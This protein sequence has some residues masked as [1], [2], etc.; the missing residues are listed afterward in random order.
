MAGKIKHSFTGLLTIY[1]LCL[2]HW[3]CAQSR[4]AQFEF[5]HIQQKDGL[6][7][8]Q[9]SCFLQDRDGFLWVGT[10]DGL[11]RYDGS[12]FVRFKNRRS[13]TNSLLHNTI[14]ALCED[15]AGNIWMAVERGIG[16]YEKKTGRFRS[17]TS[18]NGRELGL[19]TNILSDRNGDI[20]FTSYYAGLYCYRIKTGIFEWFSFSAQDTPQTV[21]TRIAV[22]GLV[23]DPQRNGLWLADKKEGLR[24]FDM[25]LRTFTDYPNDNQLRNYQGHFI[26]SL[27]RDGNRLVFADATEKHIV[28]YD[29]INRTAIKKITPVSNIKA[30]PFDIATIFVDRQHN[31]WIS[32]WNNTNFFAN[33]AAGYRIS[34]LEHKEANHLSIAGSFFRAGW[35]HPDGSVWLATVNGISL[36]NPKQAFYTVYNLGELLPSLNDRLGIVAFHEDRDGSWWLGT[37]NRQLAHYDPKSNR[38][39]IYDLPKTSRLDTYVRVIEKILPYDN[40]L[41]IGT[42]NAIYRFD[43]KNKTFKTISA[44]YPQVKANHMLGFVMKG[45]ELW[46]SGKSRA[47]H[48]YQV[49]TGKWRSYPIQQANDDPKFVVRYVLADRNGDIWIHMFPFGFAR[50][51]KETGEFISAQSAADLNYNPTI[52]N[53]IASCM[54]DSSGT[55]WMASNGHGLLRFDPSAK[56]FERFTESDGLAYD[57]NQDALPDHSGNI[58][59]GAF[60]QF[61]VYSP[62]KKQFIQFALPFNE[63][64]ILYENRLYLLNSGH[65][66]SALRGYLVEFSPEKVFSKPSKVSEKILISQVSIGDTS[67]LL[68]GQKPALNL[69]S[70][71]N[72]FAI[73][74]AALAPASGPSLQ[75]HYRLNGYDDWKLAGTETSVVYNKISGGNYK[76]QVKAIT[77]SG[78]QT[79]ISELVIHIDAPFYETTWFWTVILILIF[80]LAWVFFK[81]KARQTARVH[82]LQVQTT[83]L[84]RD[85]KEIQYQNLINHLNPHFLFNSLTSLNSLITINP[86][87]ASKFLR[88]LSIIYRYILQNKDKELVTLA[89]ELQFAQHY[90]D[91]QTSRFEDALKISIQ[92]SPEY[93]SFRIVPV[94][95]QNLLENAIKHNTLDE[96]SPLN[97]RIY[98]EQERLCVAN[99]LQKKSF[100]ETSNKQGLDSLKSLY[101]FLSKH[102]IEVVETATQ[103]CVKVPLL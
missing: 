8:N 59:V 60:N 10:F 91:L 11:N 93:L 18:V 37:S 102:D 24:Y 73:Q 57:H 6:S 101:K 89:D 34:E 27:A 35:Q 2:A 50:L 98:T 86:R 66:L 78:Y 62:R 97:I 45:D 79:P 74:F 38:L 30:D 55:F 67:Y 44:P 94:T 53:T 95:I 25:A 90:I 33:A 99:D 47:V 82:R 13:N 58:W 46:V 83:R 16:F 70:D 72:S 103:F 77:A 9:V 17:F 76:F 75:Y 32:S 23:Q 43:K 5:R 19:C 69:N 21:S 39:D 7:F 41:F 56:R 52:A 49:R 4:D 54:L 42:L 61:S 51:S 26:T 71:D 14:H 64:D 28:I 3:I 63:S 36:T 29:L 96:E 81:Y 1:L 40:D 88:K 20:W 85:M 48:C 80:V 12:H 22:Q 15:Q 84:E 100:V 31:L 87:E 68:H 65:V 92:V